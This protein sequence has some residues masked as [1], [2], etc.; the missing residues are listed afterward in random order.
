[1]SASKPS[2]KG[3]EGAAFS[4]GR[5]NPHEISPALAAEQCRELLFLHGV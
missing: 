5:K 3:L 1:M 2:L 4:C